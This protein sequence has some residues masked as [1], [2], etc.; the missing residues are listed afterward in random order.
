MKLTEKT[1]TKAHRVLL[2][3]APKSGKT[4]LAGDLA[5]DPDF[6]LIMFDLENGADTLLKLP[7]SAQERVEL[8]SLP[9]TRSYPIAIETMLKVIKGGPCEICEL[10]GK[11]SCALCR[12]DPKNKFTSI[13]LNT[14][15][16]TTIVIVDSLTQLTNSAIAHITKAQP[17]DYK[18]TYDDW[19][20]LGKLMDTFLSHVQQAPFNII[21]ISHETEVEMEDGKNKLVP[22]QE[23]EILVETLQ[24]ISTKLS[25]AKLKTRSI[26]RHHHQHIPTI[27]LQ[28]VERDLVL[29][30]N[31][32]HHLIKYLEHLNQEYLKPPQETEQ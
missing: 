28:E 22:Q 1:P 13:T 31:Q 11:I 32:M 24:S 10:H 20:N 26:L 7:Q 2:F 5:L 29:K 21:C 30:H 12:K 27:Y 6:S 8:I 16:L 14:L 3:G 9:D 25:T 18:L 23:L 15:P 17:E 19:G 4:Q